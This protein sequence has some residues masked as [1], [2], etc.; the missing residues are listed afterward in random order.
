MLRVKKKPNPRCAKEMMMF[1]R[2]KKRR[3]SK[4]CCA[5]QRHT[6][7]TWSRL[8]LFMYSKLSEVQKRVQLLLTDAGCAVISC[9]Q[10]SDITPMHSGLDW[11]IQKRCF[12]Y[13]SLSTF[14]PA[15]YQLYF[16]FFNYL[17]FSFIKFTKGTLISNHYFDKSIIWFIFPHI[18][19]SEGASECK[20]EGTITTS[21]K[22]KR[23]WEV[24]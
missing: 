2:G 22:K 17:E 10:V 13:S 18:R 11:L 8:H 14:L 21:I 3:T 6:A 19:L 4:Q 24:F 1:G 20:K 15:F 16:S 12:I 7:G 23:H 9:C 5:F